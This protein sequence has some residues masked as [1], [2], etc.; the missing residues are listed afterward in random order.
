[1]GALPSPQGIWMQESN[2]STLYQEV[3]IW[4]I[5]QPFPRT[6]G[7]ARTGGFVQTPKGRAKS[8]NPWVMATDP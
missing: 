3:Y 8:S 6:C 7:I 2:I 1:M 5:T 4:L